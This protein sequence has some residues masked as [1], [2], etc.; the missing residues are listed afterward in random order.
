MMA[1]RFLRAS[2]EKGTA[3]PES[4]TPSHEPIIAILPFRN[5]NNT[6]KKTLPAIASE[7]SRDEN[8]KLI[9]VDSNSEDGGAITAAEI[10]K[11]SELN[12]NSWLIISVDLPGKGKALN[13]A[14]DLVKKDEIVVLI[15]ADAIIPDGSFESFRRWMA[16]S[17]VG[18]VSAEE[19]ISKDHPMKEYKERANILRRYESTLGCCL[20][21]E[22]SLL[23]WHPSR[24]GWK[25]FDE[26]TNADDAQ[27]SLLSIRSGHRSIVDSSIK[28]AD[29]RNISVGSFERSIRRS[30]G[31]IK[32]LISNRDIFWSSESNSTRI[33][34]FFNY[35]LHIVTP[36][37]VLLLFITPI[38][39][40][41]IANPTQ[42][43]INH[44][45]KLLLASFFLAL[46]SFSR[47]CKTLIKGTIASVI[48]QIR[49]V[50]G[51]S[52]HQWEPGKG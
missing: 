4:S 11:N 19:H 26:S 33:S 51:I 47:I 7:V 32:Q 17:D 45:A 50:F 48:S 15:D 1:A 46:S 24:I 34:L 21:L 42:F 37:C 49:L 23:A 35:L 5:E 29:C 38:Y 40:L 43:F 9:L 12:A 52:S 13:A 18:A 36:W 6:L 27:I 3:S 28:Y 39:F 14:M 30:Q 16:S 2:K 10:M 31:L 41:F 22:G 25:R 8:S 44:E 20:I